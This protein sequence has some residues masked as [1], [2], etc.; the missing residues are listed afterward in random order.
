[1]STAE[2]LVQRISAEREKKTGA[3]P[4]LTRAR[5]SLKVGVDLIDPR[6]DEADPHLVEKIRGAATALGVHV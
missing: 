3:P 5:L 4:Q 2:K 6:E 1:M